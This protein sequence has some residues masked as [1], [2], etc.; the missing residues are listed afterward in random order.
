MAANAEPRVARSWG[1]RLAALSLSHTSIDCYATF[2]APII[3][4]VLIPKFNLSAQAGAILLSLGVGIASFGQPLL[5]YLSDR[6]GGRWLVILSPA[7]AGLCAG[8][9]L[10]V[11]SLPWLVA[12]V[13]LNALAIAAFHPEATALAGTVSQRPSAKTTA[14][15]IAAGPMGI[16]LGPLLITW[17]AAQSVRPWWLSLIGVTATV[18]L[19]FS[20]PHGAIVRKRLSRHFSLRQA[21]SGRWRAMLTLVAISSTRAFVTIGFSLAI[22]VMLMERLP[23]DEALRDTG[24]WLSGFLGAGAI[25][26]LVSSLVMKRK[27]E[28]LTNIISFSLAAPLLAMLAHVSGSAVPVV[29]GLGGLALGCTNPIIVAMGQRVAP[30]AAAVASALMLGFSWGTGG[31]VAPIV[32]QAIRGVWTTEWAMTCVA[33]MAL[34]AALA[35]CLLPRESDWPAISPTHG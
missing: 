22:P 34:L 31:S 35:S 19:F 9:F 26:G 13:I 5:G 32:F 3:P 16:S 14:V 7:L 23:Y 6:M 17:V 15:F 25:G 21:L 27:Y 33:G 29:L 1:Y 4:L 8:N 12:L 2:L 10:S 30:G 28:R 20:L 18:M 11:S 24:W